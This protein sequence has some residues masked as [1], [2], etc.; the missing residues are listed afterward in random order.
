MNK[1]LRTFL[2]FFGAWVVI[3]VSNEVFFHL[4]VKGHPLNDGLWRSNLSAG[5]STILGCS[6]IYKFWLKE[7]FRKSNQ[8][9]PITKKNNASSLNLYEDAF[10]EYENNRNKGLYAKLFAEENGDENKV[11]ARYI[12]EVVQI[13]SVESNNNSYDNLPDDEKKL[14]KDKVEKKDISSIIEELERHQK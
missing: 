2:V 13:K 3:K 1:T 10:N 4:F 7:K 8:N 6:V 11:K 5:L 9:Q 12:Q 14:L